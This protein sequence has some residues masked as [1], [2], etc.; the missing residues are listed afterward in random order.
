MSI[1][2]SDVVLR[3]VLPVMGGLRDWTNTAL[4]AASL[5]MRLRFPVFT[6]D[7]G[8]C[9]LPSEFLQAVSA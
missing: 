2:L 9:P 1:K 6:A 3:D 7:L 4:L 8:L 5:A